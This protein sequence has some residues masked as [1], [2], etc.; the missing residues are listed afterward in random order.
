MILSSVSHKLPQSKIS[1]LASWQPDMAHVRSRR[2]FAAENTTAPPYP[3]PASA[4]QVWRTATLPQ[5]AHPAAFTK[6]MHN[7]L[8]LLSVFPPLRL[9]DSIWTPSQQHQ[10]ELSQLLYLCSACCAVH[11][12]LSGYFYFPRWPFEIT[13]KHRAL[14]LLSTHVRLA[15]SA[16]IFTWHCNRTLFHNLTAQRS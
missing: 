9:R 4:G 2:V 8:L 10:Y 16:I 11:A 13:S 14:L 5:P 12:E 6:V 7:F 1:R 3:T 15:Q